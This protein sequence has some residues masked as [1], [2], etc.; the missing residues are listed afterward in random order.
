MLTNRV[1]YNSGSTISYALNR[2]VISVGVN[3]TINYYPS[4]NTGWYVG[5]ENQGYTIYGQDPNDSSKPTIW[6]TTGTSSSDII[7]LVNGL[8]AM[9]GN[10]PFSSS[11]EALVWISNN[12]NF[13]ISNRDYP[14]IVTSGMV[15]CYDVG[16]TPSYPTSGVTIYDLSENQDHGTLVNGPIYSGSNGGFLTFSDTSLEYV[17]APNIG[18]LPQWTVEVWFRL[19]KSL[20]GKVTSIASNQFDLINKL[21]FSIGT[22]NAPANRNLAVGFFNGAWRNTTGFAPQVGEWYQVVGTYDGSV[23]KQYV[24]GVASG[25]T[26]NYVGTPQSGG[27]V[28]LMARWDS[29]SSAS[30]F[31]DGDLAITYIYNRAL[32]SSEVSNNF[33]EVSNR[34]EII[35]PTPTPTPTNTPTATITITPTLTSSETATP[36]PTITQTSSPVVSGNVQMDFYN[37]LTATTVNNIVI[38]GVNYSSGIFPMLPLEN[39]TITGIT[40]TNNE[41]G[42]QIAYDFPSQGTVV[43]YIYVY[44]DGSLDFSGQTAFDLTLTIG[45]T[46]PVQNNSV[47]TVRQYNT[48][49]SPTP[50]PTNTQTKT[51][52]PTPTPTNTPTNTLTATFTPTPSPTSEPVTGYPFNLVALPY[53]FPTSGNSIM[54]SAVGVSGSTNINDLATASRGFYFNT[55]D[56]NDVDRTNYFSGF[57]GQSVTITFTQTGSTAIYSGDTL[58]FKQWVQSPQ[59]SGFVFGTNIGVPPVGTPSGSAILIQ[60]ANTQ[61]T[62]GLPVYVSLEINTP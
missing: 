10:T 55:I 15:L 47:I 33:S 54:N 58:S 26:L 13:L 60:S 49:L 40:Q 7:D 6:A 16:Y 45:T 19:N 17:D 34:F 38:N 39:G 20:D 1:K 43:K 22:N 36:T 12:P 42:L 9:S 14:Q 29:L 3:D 32:S 52:T 27:E 48:L 57:T 5:L 8:P 30:D 53:N 51:A 50:T 62:I 23:L 44:V 24:N 59:G 25:G 2:N 11:T 61:Y 18:D 28:R 37:D 35:S 56:A 4:N 31:V 21:N 46:I 41:V